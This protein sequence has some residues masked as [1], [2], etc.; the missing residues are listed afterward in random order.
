MANPGV[1]PRTFSVL[2]VVYFPSRFAFMRYTLAFIFIV[3]LTTVAYSQEKLPAS[4]PLPVLAWMGVPAEETSEARFRELK[5]AGISLNFVHY[6]DLAA[7]EKALETGKKTGV[8]IVV[9]CPEL[10]DEPEKTVKRLMNHPAVGGYYLRDEPSRKDFPELGEWA[11]RIQ[12]VDKSKF[13]YVNLFPTYA[14]K[15]QLGTETYREYVET[16]VKEVPIS[17]I[18]FDHYP[19]MKNRVSTKDYYQNMEIVADIARKSDRDLWAFSLAVA[20]HDYAIPTLAEMKF[21]VYS[22]LAYGAQTVQ[23]FT[24][25]TPVTDVWDFHHAPITTEGKRTDTYEHIK[26]INREI[27]ALAG[28]FVGSKVVSVYHTGEK[29]PQGTR[30]ITKLPEKIRVLETMGEG[31]VVSVMEKGTDTFLVIVNRDYKQPMKLTLA[32]DAD[33]RKVLKDGTL[34]PAGNY[35]ST[36]SVDPG[37]AAIYTWK[38]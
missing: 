18:S 1:L 19:L 6:P 32:A 16:F 29:I 27:Q 36:L 22:I 14:S 21:Q 25:W 17:F 35:A 11:K 2:T 8:K 5:E 7:V 10:K 33:V 3:V 23:Y 20:F 13:C 38:K 34:V 31:A 4:P 26:T 37:D 24:Y 15:E 28:V 12:S 30:R 9:A